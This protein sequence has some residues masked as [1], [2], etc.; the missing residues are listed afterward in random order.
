MANIPT[1]TQIL[2]TTTLS[3][4]KTILNT[5]LETLRVAHNALETAIA[6]AGGIKYVGAWDA[7]LNVPTLVDSTGL[8]GDYYVVAV[9]GTTLL[10]GISS[11]GVGDWV[12]FN[13]TNWTKLK[14]A[15]IIDSVN[16]K[17][18]TIVLKASDIGIT[19]LAGHFASTDV[20]GALAENAVASSAGA[21]AVQPGA[22][23]TVLSSTPG[24]SGDVPKADGAGG[25][26]WSSPFASLLTT[27]GDIISYD[28]SPVRL[29]V[30]ADGESIV[31]NSAQPS[32]L[33]YRSAVTKALTGAY[34]VTQADNGSTLEC[35]GTFTVTFPVNL[36]VGFEVGVVNVGTG[37]ITLAA[38]SG[39]TLDALATT[40]ETK[41]AA[42]YVYSKAGD[43]FHALGDLGAF[44]VSG[45]DMYKSVYD[46]NADGIV[47]VSATSNGL[48]ET[49]GPTTL[50]LG[51][52]SDGQYLQRVG[53]TLVGSGN[54]VNAQTGTNYTLTLADAGA[55]V[56][57]NNAA[58]SIVTIPSDTDVVFPIGSTVRVAQLGAGA[59]TLAAGYGVTILS[60]TNYLTPAA[61]YVALFL[62]KLSANTWLLSGQL[63][64]AAIV[65]LFPNSSLATDAVGVVGTSTASHTTGIISP[66]G[67]VNMVVWNQTGSDVLNV[68]DYRTGISVTPGVALNFSWY[69]KAGYANCMKHQIAIVV[70][71]TTYWLNP[72]GVTWSTTSYEYAPPFLA[73][74][75]WTRYSTATNPVPAG[76]T[77][78]LTMS[79]AY[80]NV[81]AT[82]T[83]ELALLQVTEGPTLHPYVPS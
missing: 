44:T 73:N 83:T 60:E 9:A 30:G 31:A 41:D 75:T 46:K 34:I 36:S 79:A 69:A 49:S 27:P 14:Q 13:G 21:T 58:P 11:W 78:T 33:E 53:T 32:G 42:A 52:V 37:I 28:T 1:L 59:V 6:S 26:A 12:I 29:P 65:N 70:D 80:R 66:Y 81:S 77:A 43:I 68:I 76:T 72:D 48:T 15:S 82:F 55:L 45:G 35:T 54:T 40:L 64:T 38:G 19:D 51:A 47:D 16:G 17:T 22:L 67:T 5:N 3:D 57:M 24:A 39:A 18:G 50:L 74:N 20:E 2:S 23:L 63:T 62:T 8:P 25:I 61:Q 4:G 71:S 10:G 7:S 56:T